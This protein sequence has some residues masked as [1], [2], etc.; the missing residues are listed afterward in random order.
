M[1][2]VANSFDVAIA[3]CWSSRHECGDSTRYGWSQGSCWS[4]RNGF[5][6]QNCVESFISPECVSHFERLRVS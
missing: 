4:N 5:L 1:T 3:G 2:S 6:V